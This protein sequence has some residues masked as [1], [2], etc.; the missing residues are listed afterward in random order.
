M[1]TVGARRAGRP[2]KDE[3]GD[4]RAALLAAALKLFVANGFGATSVRMIAR[5][6]GLS[7]GGLYAHFR[8]K[9]ALYEAL[10]A[11]AGPGFVDDVVESLLP[12]QE[13]PGSPEECLRDL[14]TRVLDHFDTPDSRAF[15][16]L[17][18]R[19]ELPRHTAVVTGMIDRGSLAL[20][21][22][23]EAW[24]R[25]GLLRD[26]VTARLTAGTI[27]GVDLAWELLAPLAFV[28][29]VYLHGPGTTR[30]RGRDRVLV[31]LDLFLDAVVRG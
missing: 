31:H 6:A 17:L 23:F 5:E 10:V 13:K 15:S 29:L 14:V 8:S 18:L 19:E 4:T 11:G 12:G 22:V 16:L 24:A 26:D 9:Q 3:A 27:T 2:R 1:A 30:R 20:G 7:D 21:P 28:R 25:D